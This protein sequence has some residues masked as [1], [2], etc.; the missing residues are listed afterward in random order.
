MLY[1]RSTWNAHRNY[2]NTILYFV[3]IVA[4]A[5]IAST[6]Q[7]TV[8]QDDQ[9]NEQESSP[10]MSTGL[11][12]LLPA[13]FIILAVAVAGLHYRQKHTGFFLSIVLYL[14]CQEFEVEKKK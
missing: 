8:P 11:S 9:A 14:F 13:I 4:A 2:Q 10:S 12:I 3:F 7:E 5:D 1:T 6:P